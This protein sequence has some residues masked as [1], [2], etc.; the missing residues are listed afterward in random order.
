MFKAAAWLIL[1][2]IMAYVAL[3][4]TE[5]GREGLRAQV[6]QQFGAYYEGELEIGSLTGNLINDLYATDVRLLDPDGET[7]LEIDSLT[8]RP[9]WRYLLNRQLTI[10]S[11]DVHNPEVH[12]RR[13][14]DD[15]WNLAQA[16]API[17]AEPGD[18][19][20]S[21]VS[22]D[23]QIRGG[24]LSTQ[25]DG[26]APE[27][28]EAGHLFDYAQSRVENVN[29]AG[30][31][32]W[33]PEGRFI[34]VREFSGHLPE[35][36]LD[37][38]RLYGQFVLEDGE[39]SISGLNLA[40]GGSHLEASVALGSLAAFRDGS[41]ADTELLVNLRSAGFDFSELRRLFPSLPLA[42][43]ARLSGRVEGT[44]ADLEIGA[45]R[46][47][48]GASSLELEG[49]LT[50]LP[51]PADYTLSRL[52]ATL[53]PG[54]VDALYPQ[55]AP[56]LARLEAHE[57][58]EVS[59]TSEGH[60]ER[61]GEGVL[62]GTA[63]NELQVGGGLG[64]LS[65]P[66]TLTHTRDDS[67]FYEGELAFSDLNL[68]A[69]LADNGPESRLNGQLIIDGS[70]ARTDEL[71]V[72][73][74][75]NLHN[76]V[77]WD[78]EVAALRLDL[79]VAD[80]RLD[81]H[82][83]LQQP[84]T[85]ELFQ[86]GQLPLSTP[87]SIAA[88]LTF[89]W[90]ID[91]PHY[92]LDLK[93]QNAD[94]GRLLPHD[95]LSTA[96]NGRLSAAGSGFSWDDAETRLALDVDSSVVRWGEQLR[97][98]D[99]HRSSFHLAESTDHRPRLSMEGDLG[100][101]FLRG[102]LQQAPLTA[103]ASFWSDAL[104]EAA[105]DE[106]DK[107]YPD[108][109]QLEADRATLLPLDT[110]SL[111]LE[112]PLAPEPPEEQAKALLAELDLDSL[113]IETDFHLFRLDLI[114]SL[115][116]MLP[117]VSG[118]LQ[119]AVRSDLSPETLSLSGTV[120]GS[121]IRSEHFSMRESHL[122]MRLSGRQ[123]P[124]L[125]ETIDAQVDVRAEDLE[126]R[127]ERADEAALK[128]HLVDEEL[129]FA[130]TSVA[131]D[132]DGPV[133]AEGSLDLLSDRNRLR[134]DHLEL[135][136]G[137]L[138][139]SSAHPT[140]IDLYAGAVAV[141]DFALESAHPRTDS[142]QHIR[143]EGVISQNTSDQLVLEASD[144]GLLSLTE[145]LLD[146]LPLDGQL[147]VRAQ[148]SNLKA[149]ELIGSLEI[150]TLSY[151]NRVLG[152][153]EASS[154][155][156]PG[157]SGIALAA[158][159]GPADSLQAREHVFDSPLP[160]LFEDNSLEIDGTFN[161]PEF[162]ETGSITRPSH[163]DLGFTADRIDAFFFDYLFPEV[164]ENVQGAFEGA[165]TI[166]GSFSDPVFD[167]SFDL[168]GGYV[169]VPDFNLAYDVEGPV[170]ID[171]EGFALDSVSVTD[172][173]GGS[174]A[175]YGDILFNDYEYFSFDL[176]ADLSELRFMNVRDDR[177]LPFYGHIWASG[178]VTLTGPVYATTL[179]ST[180]LVTNSR[181]ELYIPVSEAADV[182][183]PGFIVFTDSLHQTREWTP[184]S[185][186]AHIL[187]NRPETE[188]TFLDG[189]DL[190]LNFA[191]PRGSTVHLVFDPLL[192]DAVRA[193]GSGRIQLQRQEGDF[194]TYGTFEVNSGDYL[195][196]AGEVFVR[197]F[198][199]DEGTITWDGDPIDAQLDIQAAYRTRASRAGLTGMQSDGPPIPLAV[200]LHI[201]G[202]VSTP[203]VDLD[204]RIDQQ[205][206]TVLAAEQL[207]AI[208]SQPEQ[209]TEY[210]TS[211]LLTNSFLLTTQSTESDFLTG[212][213][214]NSVSQLVSSQLNRY[215]NEVLPNVDFTFGV[216]GDENVQDLDVTYGLAL[217][218]L[219]ERL[220]IRGQGI[221]SGGQTRGASDDP[222]VGLGLQQQ[223][224][225][226]EFIVEMRLSPRVAVEVFY[227][228]EGDLLN[229][230]QFT[231]TTGAGLSYQT[232][233]PSWRSLFNTND[234]SS[235]SDE[236][237]KEDEPVVHA[238]DP[239]S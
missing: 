131:G 40:L 15:T 161:L 100:T 103:L 224:L 109:S 59:L 49:H 122:E 67:L 96:L 60:L 157:D 111:N 12:L 217:R 38:S 64:E 28:V 142:T 50:G 211:V 78:R 169:E 144:L 93:T 120:E 178:P 132:D 121:D 193:V 231:N 182:E 158:S 17:D 236:D 232:S 148:L 205:E 99:P 41:W 54:D 43:S 56:F 216:Q 62:Y 215:L 69:F 47:E 61:S 159:L 25:N 8:A 146:G 107:P 88:E 89:D 163:F 133:L 26:Q 53:E 174:A 105:R 13:G 201:T 117:E 186:R 31:V 204:L 195:F 95:S 180:N 71:H 29:L 206:R 5:V 86:T 123:Q 57:A 202:R 1:I 183:D 30:T 24:V 128:A 229:V 115:F 225:Q 116:P 77:L 110:T 207:Q 10:R 151:R 91:E 194:F 108:A 212:S 70:G 2:G 162:D 235:S 185:R 139:W 200:G 210:A 3:T 196:T 155:Y 150:E 140:L 165:G 80:R 82:F 106:L 126:L 203:A 175:I 6:E 199:I 197:R 238:N 192:G 36:A 213:A 167:A 22:S 145:P 33:S 46:V 147:N 87:G 94:L 16:L 58:V 173:T 83:E 97:L 188:R 237:E 114:T 18:P 66:L 73:A 141:H 221:Y 189:M 48:R 129:F 134:L 172:P 160:M 228:R 220:I 222:D 74:G 143:A 65:G 90:A 51:G 233:F 81:A 7:V 27:I 191:A 227:R 181:S 79:G 118:A 135:T 37:L 170:T 21:F 104:R 9:G 113:H 72:V 179:R 124:S 230:N 34:D 234:R 198:S 4:K 190:D 239:D 76:S 20:W 152:R 187:A 137:P 125:T 44:L 127:E 119:G 102:D 75:G 149:P 11:L 85:A 177:N 42:D 209:Q 164:I 214:F 166:T 112:A 101:F 168:E 52:E 35:A 171:R 68:G 98:V 138:T 176:E 63:E 32:E 23:V 45:F 92:E 130:L 218:L 19:L 154:E 226:G 153:F 184:V 39:L 55:E 208:L 219:D 223:G 14:E 84:H 156:V 136:T